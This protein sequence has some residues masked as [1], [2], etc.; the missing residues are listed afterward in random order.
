MVALARHK[1]SIDLVQVSAGEWDLTVDGRTEQV[2][3]SEIAARII[4]L[5]LGIRVL[6]HPSNGVRWKLSSE[7][8]Q[9]T[10]KH[11]IE[12]YPAACDVDRMAAA[13][14]AAGWVEVVS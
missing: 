9:C 10:D 6:E 1:R 4:G 3:T 2:I 12:E 13:L 8:W 7:V 14:K 5:A 11:G